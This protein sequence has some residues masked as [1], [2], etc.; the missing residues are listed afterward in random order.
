MFK[1]FRSRT[2]TPL[3]T[4]P[5]HPSET[6]VLGTVV[7]A[8]SVNGFLP[9]IIDVTATNANPFLFSAV[10][11]ASQAVILFPFL[12]KTSPAAFGTPWSYRE[13]LRPRIVWLFWDRTGSRPRSPR[14]VGEWARSP[15]LWGVA[16]NLAF[17]WFVMATRYVDAVTVAVIF[18]LWV[19]LT[20]FFLNR[21][22]RLLAVGNQ[23]PHQISPRHVGLALAAF[24]GVAF[25]V[26]SETAQVD[27]LSQW[28]SAM[29]GLGLAFLAATSAAIGAPTSINISHLARAYLRER[30]PAQSNKYQLIWLTVYAMM[31]NSAFSATL[32]LVVGTA[33]WELVG[34]EIGWRTTFGGAL[35]GVSITVAGGLIRWTLH[36]TPSLG[37]QVGNYIT[38]VVAL[39]LL[40]VFT[41]V[42]VARVD[43]L[44]IGAALIVAANVLI[45]PKP[46][47]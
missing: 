27:V 2:P 19:L 33:S 14:K 28:A 38:P 45:R 9:L 17:V 4:T 47:K 42:T 11:S 20:V 41:D 8:A 30:N 3:G 43:F 21:L 24:V 34:G 22:G 31:W 25:V 10:S 44:L 26:L 13:M 23:R 5:V 36:A 1:L 6:R 12:K 46:V 40:A 35:L 29:I 37:P 39:T 16:G 7:L 15:A 32:S 18:Q